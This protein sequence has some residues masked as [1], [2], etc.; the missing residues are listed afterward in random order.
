MSC[1][2][3]KMMSTFISICVGTD[4]KTDP[5]MTT[6]VAETIYGH[7]I[8]VTKDIELMYSVLTLCWKYDFTIGWQRRILK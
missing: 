7:M 5:T 4:M 1:L 3:K 8:T 6:S 2:V